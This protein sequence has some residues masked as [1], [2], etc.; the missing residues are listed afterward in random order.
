MAWGKWN[1]GLASEYA[2]VEHRVDA[3]KEATFE[4]RLSRAAY[5]KMMAEK[6]AIYGKARVEK[7]RSWIRK[8]AKLNK[9]EI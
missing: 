3:E 1:S 9:D 6:E 8:C 5:G 4:S 2:K 7:A